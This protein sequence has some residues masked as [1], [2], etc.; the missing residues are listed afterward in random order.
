MYHDCE[1]SVAEAAAARLR[2]QGQ[3]AA[4]EPS[5]LDGW[6]GVRATYVLCA[7]DRMYEPGFA[8]E[9]AARLRVEPTVIDGGH[10]PFLSRP[11]ELAAVLAE[12]A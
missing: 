12:V 7:E 10:S 8:R 5:P 4:A 11:G 9:M 2:P 6:A 3:R 1:R